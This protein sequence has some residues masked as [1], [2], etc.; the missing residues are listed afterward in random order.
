MSEYEA[1]D[2]KAG[3]TNIYAALAEEDGPAGP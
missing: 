1:S 2:K 3:G